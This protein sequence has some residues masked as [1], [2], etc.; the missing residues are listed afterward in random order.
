ML[1]FTKELVADLAP[2]LLKIAGFFHEV[3]R[4]AGHVQEAVQGSSTGKYVAQKADEL[5]KRFHAG[6]PVQ[7][8]RA[9]HAK[10]ME[11]TKKRRE[12]AINIPAHVRAAISKMEK[13]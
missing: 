1:N 7:D 9:G 5:S 11:E 8:L 3:G 4:Q 2:E 13:K 12:E 10:G 6:S